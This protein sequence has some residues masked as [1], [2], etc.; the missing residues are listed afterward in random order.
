MIEFLRIDYTY[1]DIAQTSPL[2]R[3]EGV[4]ITK[5]LAEFKETQPDASE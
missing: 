2:S 1:Y 3:G 4:P 5:S